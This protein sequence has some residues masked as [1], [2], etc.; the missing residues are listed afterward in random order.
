MIQYAY[1]FTLCKA[2]KDFVMRLHVFS[3]RFIMV[4]P[5]RLRLETKL[6]I[7]LEAHSLSQPI[8]VKVIVYAFDKESVLMRDSAILNSDNRY[9]DLKTIEVCSEDE[10]YLLS[11][12]IET[13]NLKFCN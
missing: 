12:F 8:T 3:V 10:V 2:D 9:S 13:I 11:V 6:N 4:A 7:L 5:A 1:I